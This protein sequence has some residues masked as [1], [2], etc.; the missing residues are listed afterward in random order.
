M[1]DGEHLWDKRTQGLVLS[2]FFWGYLF[3]QIPGGLLAKKYGP[4]WTYAGFQ[5][6]ASVLTMLCPLATRVGWRG[7]LA[8]RFLIGFCAGVAFPCFNGLM[9]VWA[10]PQERSALVSYG[11]SGVHAGKFIVL[12][13]GSL[14]CSFVSWDSIFYVFGKVT[15]LLGCTYV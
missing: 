13:L 15:G 10:P 4:R 2:S 5:F 7:L 14:L 9:G 8:M 6:T 1:R 12:P 11:M 3:T